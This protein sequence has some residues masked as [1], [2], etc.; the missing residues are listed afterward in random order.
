MN[1]YM[2]LNSR[3]I[4]FGIPLLLVAILVLFSQ[5]VWFD[6]NPGLLAT[7][8]TVDFV[9]IVPLVYLLLIW[10]TDIPKITALPFLTGGLIIASYA[11]PDNQQTLLTQVKTWVIPVIEIGVLSFVGYNV[12]KIYKSYQNEKKETFD[13]Y[14]A[15]KEAVKPI[16]PKAAQSFFAMEISTFYYGFFDWKKRKLKSHEYSYH[17]ESGTIAI[18]AVIILLVV[19]ETAVFHILIQ[20]WSAVIAWILSILSVY[21]GIQIFGMLRSMSKR[22][23]SIEENNLKLHFGIMAESIVPISNIDRVELSAKE[24]EL[25]DTTKKLS[26]LGEIDS[27][28]VLIHMKDTQ[29]LYGLYGFQKDY[30]TIALH[31][32]DKKG[33]N[34]VLTRAIAEA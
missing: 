12:R 6:S 2:T 23:I 26:P 30:T 20:R 4:T 9:L 21:S 29:K 25:N 33:F 15:M 14:S 22:P 11:L 16:L 3:I 31:V 24:V 8:I 27:H 28:N 1:R 17:K 32:D 13:F 19:V 10:K 5:S 34:E 18:L 7:G